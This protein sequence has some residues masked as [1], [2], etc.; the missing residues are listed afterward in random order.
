MEETHHD[1]SDCFSYRR[2]GEN[3]DPGIAAVTAV[4][5]EYSHNAQD[6]TKSQQLWGKLGSRWLCM[7]PSCSLFKILTSSELW[8]FPSVGA[9]HCQKAN[10]P[11][12]NAHPSLKWERGPERM[13]IAHPELVP[14]K[15][16]SMSWSRWAALDHHTSCRIACSYKE[17]LWFVPRSQCRGQHSPVA[18]GTRCKKGMR[19]TLWKL[20]RL[21]V[22]QRS[23]N[24]DCN[25]HSWWGFGSGEVSGTPRWGLHCTHPCPSACPE[26]RLLL[27]LRPP[28]KLHVELLLTHVMS[29]WSQLEN[30]RY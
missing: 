16:P 7:P 9:R 29:E 3:S 24:W 22:H 25:E 17:C 10:L 27:S 6:V 8:L 2:Q 13:K 5:P 30:S 23:A 20:A 11:E 19:V 26:Q 15:W 12:G 4:S 1:G 18:A 21:V 28:G 14:W